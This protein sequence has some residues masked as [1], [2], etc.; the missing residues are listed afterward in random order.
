MRDDYRSHLRQTL[1]RMR[2]DGFY[3]AERVIAT[4]QAPDMEQPEILTVD[5][6]EF[7]GRA[8]VLEDIG[9]ASHVA[10]TPAPK[11]PG[12]VIIAGDR[13]Q[14]AAPGW[15]LPSSSMCCHVI[16]RAWR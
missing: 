4:P 9:L 14:M 1:E 2:A 8:N 6:D 13:A 15:G 3:K 12:P 10:L 11:F 5:P 7:L 16:R